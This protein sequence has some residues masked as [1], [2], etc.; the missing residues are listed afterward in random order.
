MKLK[1]EMEPSAAFT[2]AKHRPVDTE[3]KTA[4]GPAATNLE[5]LLAK[6]LLQPSITTAWQCS[7][8]VG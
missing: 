4:L 5:I 1:R 8:C 7:E 6:L 2:D 3:L